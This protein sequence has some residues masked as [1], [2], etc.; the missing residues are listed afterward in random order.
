[1]KDAEEG[2]AAQSRAG[3]AGVGEQGRLPLLG[4][5]WGLGNSTGLVPHACPPVFVMITTGVP[6][7][8]R[9][10]RTISE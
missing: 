1:M 2:G 6:K 4:P 7:P 8:L 10:F 9:A 5:L 3:R